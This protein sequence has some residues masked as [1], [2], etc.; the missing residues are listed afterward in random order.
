[1]AG[2]LTGLLVTCVVSWIKPDDFDWSITRD[3]NA[4][5]SLYGATT[6][7]VNPD[8]DDVAT[9]EATKTHDHAA[10]PP[11]ETQGEKGEPKDPNHNHN[12]PTVRQE[13]AEEAADAAVLENPQSLQRT[14]IM[15]L[16]L[17]TVLSISM[18]FIVP[19]PMFFSHYI[20]SRKFFLFYIVVSFIWVFAALF[21]CGILPV[22]ETRTFWREL[23]G[24]IRAGGNK[25]KN[26]N[27]DVIDGSSPGVTNV[28]LVAG[29]GKS[30]GSS[31]QG[32]ELQ[33]PI[34]G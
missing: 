10:A 2:V 20:Y 16:I 26:A 30:S 23:W 3:I 19:M 14:Y 9:T 18:V 11:V 29:E 22:W 28:D 1:M 6:P 21:L 33:E 27:K 31:D 32:G 8:T 13:D 24:E 17:S 15:A 12:L 5:S 25:T 4:P 34:K 7:G